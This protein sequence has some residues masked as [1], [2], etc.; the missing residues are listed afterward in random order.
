[1]EQM[2]KA[3]SPGSLPRSDLSPRGRGG[4]EARAAQAFTSPFG[5]E[6]DAKRRVRG[7]FKDLLSPGARS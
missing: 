5:V 1:M 7:P 4:G 3:P 6:V 2:A